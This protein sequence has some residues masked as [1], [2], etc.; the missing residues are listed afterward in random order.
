MGADNCRE[1]FAGVEEGPQ[2][3]EEG[4]EARVE[5]RVQRV[6]QKQRWCQ[7]LR[8]GQG[9]EAGPGR[10]K[11]RTEAGRQMEEVRWQD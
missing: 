7:V 9:R 1:E 6:R 8:R 11:T 3:R 2:R 10:E 5:D 4:R